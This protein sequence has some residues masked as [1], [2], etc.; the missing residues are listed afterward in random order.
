VIGDV[1]KEFAKEL[2]QSK[3]EVVADGSA[4]GADA[5]FLFV[6]GNGESENIAKAAKKIRGAAG[7]WVVYAKGRKEIT[8]RDVLGAGRKAGLKDVKVV[9]FSGTHTAMKFVIPAQKR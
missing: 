2:K 7:L 3:A 8:E 9:G 4:G 6:E 1:E 5:V